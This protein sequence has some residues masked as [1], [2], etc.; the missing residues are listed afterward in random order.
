MR[1]LG[2]PR[3]AILEEWASC[4]TNENAA[5]TK[6]PERLPPFGIKG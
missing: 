1:I 5:Y 3:S 6:R 4:A 2:V